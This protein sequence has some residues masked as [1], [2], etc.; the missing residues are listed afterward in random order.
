[1]ETSRNSTIAIAGDRNEPPKT[2]KAAYRSRI[3]TVSDSIVVCSA[4]PA[5]VPVRDFAFQLSAVLA[6]IEILWDA[7]I[8]EGYTIRGAVGWDQIYWTP[9]ETIGPAFNETY[10]LE[11]VAISSRV[12]IGPTLLRAIV[13]LPPAQSEMVRDFLVV[14][15]DDEFIELSPILRLSRHTERLKAM[16]AAAGASRSKYRPLLSILCGEKQAKRPVPADLERGAAAIEHR[17]RQQEPQH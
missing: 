15:P 2:V 16:E 14:S 1:V 10:L 11:K 4:T 6:A 13:Q 17:R 8:E 5:Q 9:A 12:I 7:A 3:H